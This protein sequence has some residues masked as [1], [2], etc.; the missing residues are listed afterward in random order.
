[1]QTPDLA[2]RTTGVNLSVTQKVMI[3]VFGRAGSS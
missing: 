2:G 1:L 3:R